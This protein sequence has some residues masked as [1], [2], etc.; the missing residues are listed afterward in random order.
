LA[1]E[2]VSG[3]EK[4]E[5]QLDIL[6]RRSQDLEKR[7]TEARKIGGFTGIARVTEIERE[8]ESVD[9]AIKAL[10]DR[11][12][13]EQRFG[14]I[15]EETEKKLEKATF[16]RLSAEKA[17]IARELAE[18]LL[19][20]TRDIET[21]KKLRLLAAREL[22]TLATKQVVE[23]E[24]AR[25]EAARA[26]L[27][28]DKLI[29]EERFRFSVL[30]SDILNKS[31][32]QARKELVNKELELVLQELAAQKAAILSD[33]SKTKEVQRDLILKAERE[34]QQKILQIRREFA[35]VEVTEFIEALAKPRETRLEEEREFQRQLAKLRAE[36][37]AKFVEEIGP[38]RTKDLLRDPRFLSEF[39][40]AS[41]TFLQ[42][43]A[44]RNIGLDRFLLPSDLDAKTREALS[45]VKDQIQFA[46]EGVSGSMEKVA[47]RVQAALE[48]RVTVEIDVN[49]EDL[50]EKVRSAVED[51]FSQIRIRGIS[52]SRVKA[53][54]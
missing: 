21:Q 2:T 13:L 47:D 42:S 24:Q 48:N 32:L 4:T 50:R 52:R 31:Q 6:I 8:K 54:E 26:A 25:V 43:A 30:Q 38:E 23:E 27:S 51:V 22:T 45:K 36:G 44:A 11:I 9:K 10:E 20:T 16:D 5:Q 34:T 3:L 17:T 28:L 7:L 19:A 29:V 1:G 40:R 35:N 53:P 41:E 14:D 37:V 49:E 46:F 12:R 39:K 33:T 15:A 18:R